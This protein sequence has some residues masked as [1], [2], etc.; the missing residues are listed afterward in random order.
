[1][2]EHDDRP[3][4]DVPDLSSEDDE[5][6]ECLATDGNH[7]PVHK[8]DMRWRPSV[9]GHIFDRGRM[10]MIQLADDGKLFLP[11]GGCY[12]WETFEQALCREVHEEAGLTVT[13]VALFEV[14][15]SFHFVRRK[16]RGVN[17]IMMHYS[18]TV[19]GDPDAIKT[20]DPKEG[21]PLWIPPRSLRPEILHP[22]ISEVV[23]RRIANL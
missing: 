2:D 15:Q 16:S 6:L 14:G 13:P 18:A 12:P 21:I 19:V 3:I 1:M 20:L 17:A 7:V 10:L 22:A 23:M 5:L 9:Y 4:D 11:G 8:R